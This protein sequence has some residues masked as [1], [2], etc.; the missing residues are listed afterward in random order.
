MSEDKPIYSSE[1]AQI[2][3]YDNVAQLEGVPTFMV[4]SVPDDAVVVS[5]GTTGTSIVV[6]RRELAQFQAT[7][8]GITGEPD[9]FTYKPEYHAPVVDLDAPS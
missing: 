8:A 2:L 4:G 7:V 6:P 9:E 1:L 3:G 5:C